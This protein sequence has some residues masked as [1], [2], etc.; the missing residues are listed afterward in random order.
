MTAMSAP[1]L[2][3]ADAVFIVGA[4]AI[5]FAVVGV[6]AWRILRGGRRLADHVDDEQKY[7]T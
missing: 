2:A 1:V 4:Y 6:Y 3:I 7:W 5:T